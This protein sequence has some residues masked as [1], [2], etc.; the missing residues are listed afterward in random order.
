[1]PTDK[2]LGFYNNNGDYLVEPGSF[3]VFVGTSSENVQKT[4]FELK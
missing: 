4:E 2:E 3:K 1:M